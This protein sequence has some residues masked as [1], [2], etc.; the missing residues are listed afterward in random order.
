MSFSVCLNILK[1]SK[2]VLVNE[3]IKHY[4][5]VLTTD[6]THYLQHLFFKSYVVLRYLKLFF[7]FR[8]VFNL[9][10]CV[11]LFIILSSLPLKMQPYDIVREIKHFQDKIYS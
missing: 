4:A 5:T 6:F 8:C 9:V 11:K 7:L 10:S 1:Q 2:V 3:S